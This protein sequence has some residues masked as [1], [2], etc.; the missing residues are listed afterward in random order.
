MSNPA[1]HQPIADAEARGVA[2]RTYAV[3][4]MSCAHCVA[5]V[6]R[7]LEGVAG[8]STVDVDLPAGE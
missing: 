4:G 2:P 8:V 6:T 7:E 3:T 1:T 5:A